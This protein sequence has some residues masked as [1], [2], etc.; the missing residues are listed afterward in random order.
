METFGNCTHDRVRRITMNK[1]IAVVFISMLIP[2]RAL[3]QAA[4]YSM[5]DP[6]P[7]DLTRDPDIDMYIASWKQSMPQMSHGSLV[8]RDILTKGDPLNP[9]SPGAVLK[10]AERL[11]YAVLAP[12]AETQPVS[13]SGEQEIFY[14]L[15]GEGA[16]TSGG[17]SADLFTGIAVLMPPGIRFT[18]KNTGDS[19]LTMY[20]LTEKTVPGFKPLD[21]M[22]VVDEN[23]AAWN[24]GNPHWVGMSKPLFNKGNGLASIGNILTVTLDSRTMFHPH[25]HQEGQEEVWTAIKGDMFFLLGKE[26]R[27]QPPGTAYY[28]PPTGYTAHGNI[29]VSDST[30]KLFYFS[31][32]KD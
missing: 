23:T 8:E 9:V 15:S 6:R 3:A 27:E 21:T 13:L 7:L 30:I 5:L 24:E 16:I 10:Y 29:N 12:K 19:E 31:R 17:E 32:L 20:L 18:M 14:V 1:L 26:L 25:S 11:S 2:V 28:I 22:K 4:D